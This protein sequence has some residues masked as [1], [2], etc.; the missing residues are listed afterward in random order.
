MP[1]SS[2]AFVCSPFKCIWPW[3]P[4][5]ENW[6]ANS[7]FYYNSHSYIIIT[8]R[9]KY[10]ISTYCVSFFFAAKS[11]YSLICCCH[12]TPS[13]DKL[14]GIS[15]RDNS[16]LS[17]GTEE[18]LWKQKVLPTR[19]LSFFSTEKK[20]QHDTNFPFFCVD[21]LTRYGEKSLLIPRRSAWKLEHPAGQFL[22]RLCLC[23]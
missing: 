19:F 4:Y 18:V 3:C 12:V 8:W 20:R 17:L 6:A 1:V 23:Y 10:K 22:A 2:A 5:I 14:K 16:R 13:S 7:I 11:Q 21:F 9:E 15:Y